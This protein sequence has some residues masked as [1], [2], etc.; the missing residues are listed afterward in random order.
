MSQIASD[1]TGL[2]RGNKTKAWT[3][4]SFLLGLLALICALLVQSQCMV[5]IPHLIHHSKLGL[6][7]SE[8]WYVI[9]SDLYQEGIKEVC[10]DS[11]RYDSFP[12]SSELLLS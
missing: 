11:L 12:S 6:L 1:M 3:L 9:I 7:A 2:D 8:Y 4:V 5:R 10:S